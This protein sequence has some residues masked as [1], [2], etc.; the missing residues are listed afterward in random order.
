MA[1]SWVGTWI[2]RNRRNGATN[3]CRL[4][5]ASPGQLERQHAEYVQ[6]VNPRQHHQELPAQ[7]RVVSQ[8]AG[9]Q[10]QDQHPREQMPWGPC[11]RDAENDPDRQPAGEPVVDQ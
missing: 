9:R 5:P 4:H 8:P 3:N 10:E 1:S 7:A 11:C 2:T 6:Q